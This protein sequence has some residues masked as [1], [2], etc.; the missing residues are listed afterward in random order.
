M[1]PGG[2]WTSNVCDISKHARTNTASDLPDTLEINCARI[3]RR[4]ADEQLRPVFFGDS[5][6]LV[7][8]D[9]LRLA[10]NTVVS[11]FVT[12]SRKIQRMSVRKV[13]AVR[14]VHSQDLIAILDRGEINRHV[15]LRATVRLHIRM[16]GAKQLLRAIYRGLLDHVGPLTPAVVTLPRI[17]LSVFI[18]EH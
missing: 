1:Q 6:Q 16:I 8:I 18:C 7:V 10:R 13:T 4:T 17:T 5:L 15:R 14:Q 9:L 11:N 2:D 12:Q 3:R